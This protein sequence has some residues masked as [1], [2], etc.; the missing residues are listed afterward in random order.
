MSTDVI[1]KKQKLLLEILFTHKPSFIRCF[2][3]M[4]GSYF[5]PP[6]DG[7]VDY[8]MNHFKEYHTI[9]SMDVIDAELDVKL[10]PRDLDPADEQFLLDEIE[11][12]CQEEDMKEA[13]LS[14]VDLLNDGNMHAIAERVRQSLLIKLD[15]RV[16]T[17]LFDDPQARIENMDQNVE[18]ISMGIA[19]FDDL[20]N[21]IRRGELGAFFATTA[22]GKSVSLANVAKNLS[23]RGYTG[24]IISFELREEL[25]SKRL[26]SIFTGLDIAQHKMFAADIAEKLEELKDKDGYGR[27]VTKKMR[28]GSTPSMVRTVIMEYILLYGKA[29]DY[30]IL[31]YLTLMGVDS[32]NGRRD[33][34]RFDEDEKKVFS[35][36]DIIDEY[37][38]YGFTAGQINRDGYDI[39]NLNPSHVAGGISVI[40]ALDWA[41]GLVA[42]EE[43]IDNNQVQA[44][45]MK[46]RNGEKTTQKKTVYRCP[47]TLRLADKPFINPGKPPAKL[48]L[49]NKNEDTEKSKT[50]PAPKK[51]LRDAL[52]I[53]KSR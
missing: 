5:E 16:G 32:A 36:K 31:D 45:Q 2:R 39:T 26:D 33:M 46:V 35:V 13:I 14:S 47:R 27:V 40:N 20:T 7:V 51:K 24:L 4:K 15:S 30:L 42:T 6:L 12:L 11:K 10:K 37:N 8:V 9:P 29:P 49:G 38:M 23:K 18:E 53:G 34:N 48:K 50:N 25:Y 28:F 21:N 19:A 22:G 17:D 44:V 52:E 43:D 3:I 1:N 41:I